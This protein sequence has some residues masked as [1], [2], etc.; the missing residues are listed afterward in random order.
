[1]TRKELS[2]LE[3]G[4]LIYNGRHEGEIKM[5]GKNKVIEIWIPISSMSDESNRF[6]ERPYNWEVME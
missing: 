5:D 1:M 4:T 2:E 3:V 6:D